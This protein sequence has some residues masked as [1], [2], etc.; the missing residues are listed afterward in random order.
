MDNLKTKKVIMLVGLPSTGKTTYINNELGGLDNNFI[1]SN[2]NIRE[3]ISFKHG[4]TYDDTFER[5]PNDLMIGESLDGK[6]SYGP[7]IEVIAPWDNESKIK[8]FEKL[9]ECNKEIANV[10]EQGKNLAK[11]TFENN[12]DNVIIDMTNLS[13]KD[14]ERIVNEINIQKSKIEIVNFMPEN[15]LEQFVNDV[16]L[17]SRQREE[18]SKSNGRP[19]TIPNEVYDRMLSIYEKPT[20]EEGFKSI[21]NK[22]NSEL[23]HSLIHIKEQE[24]QNNE[25]NG[26]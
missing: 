19:K 15:N 17:L 1:L 16:K 6:E 9:W 18:E 20:L 12:I 10:F 2:D 3:K 23:I 7:I 26:I 24:L 22:D 25:I 13:I 11:M 8:V 4:F 14:R 21:I 5:V